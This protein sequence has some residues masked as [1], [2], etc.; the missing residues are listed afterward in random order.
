MSLCP[1]LLEYMIE[2]DEM[3]QSEEEEESWG[4]EDEDEEE[5]GGCWGGCGKVG[6]DGKTKR[7]KCCKSS[8]KRVGA[9]YTCEEMQY[10]TKTEIK[11]YSN[12]HY[13]R[14]VQRKVKANTT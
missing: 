5:E 4:N 8:C 13:H 3:P 11:I 2:T 12:C 10:A 14:A 6:C 1:P 7:H 9:L